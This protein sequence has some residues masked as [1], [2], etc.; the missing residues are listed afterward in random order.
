MV[1]KGIPGVPD[2]DLTFY[3]NWTESPLRNVLLSGPNGVGKST[4][5][6]AIAMLWEN[7]DEWV[8]RGKPLSE[9]QHNQ[10][11]VLAEAELIAVELRDLQLSTT[12]DVIYQAKPEITLPSLWLYIT[13]SGAA[14]KFIEAAAAG[15]F[16]IGEQ[17]GKRGKP[18]LTRTPEAEPFALLA[19]WAEYLQLGGLDVDLRLPNL[20][21]LEAETRQ[22]VRPTARPK[23]APEALYRWLVTYSASD[24]AE[25]HI[26][27]MLRNHKIRSPARFQETLAHINRFLEQNGKRLTDF[28]DNLRLLVQVGSGKARTTHFLEALSS[29][30]RQ[31]VLLIFMVSRW[32]M[33]GGVVLIDE[34]DLHMHGSWQ[35]TLIH[36]LNR[37][38]AEK[39][40]QLIITSHAEL[41]AQEYAPSQRFALDFKG[42]PA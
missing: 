16:S 13:R 3:D 40:G 24:R 39:E 41:V 1:L 19:G 33:Q 29:G 26:E 10:R 28:D 18:K 9:T 31:V 25:S 21:F 2:H 8:R 30:E 34:P 7:F 27:A 23:P 4:I 11:G 17:R 37:L 15:A 12:P 6:R 32:L 20:L 5:L 42:Q 36:E 38:V 35:R 22:I 14:A